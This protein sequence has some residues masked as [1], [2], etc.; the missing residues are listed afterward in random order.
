MPKIT[1]FLWFGAQTEEA[2]KFYLSVFND[3]TITTAGD[4]R[5]GK[6]TASPTEGTRK[7]GVVDVLAAASTRLTNIG[8]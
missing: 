8:G 6:Q 7:A 5:S 1:P 4:L 3:G 2:V